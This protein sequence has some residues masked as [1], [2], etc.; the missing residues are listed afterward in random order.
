MQGSAVK[1]S[2]FLFGTQLSPIE[3]P[4]CPH[5]TSRMMLERVN[6]GP[7]G[8]E[9]RLFEC[10][11]CDFVQNEVVASDPMKSASAGWLLGELKG[12]G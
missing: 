2:Q 5:C 7:V 4:R 1:K 10:P 9:H 6:P 12:P 8:F 3:R 11:K